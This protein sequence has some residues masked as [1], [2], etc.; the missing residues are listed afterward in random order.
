MQNLAHRLWWVQ[1]RKDSVADAGIFYKANNCLHFIYFDETGNEQS[2]GYSAL[3]VPLSG[4]R[5]TLAALKD[6]RKR[7]RASD[8][9]YTTREF[10]ATKFTSGRGR[11]GLPGRGISQQ[12]R[13]E[14]FSECLR[15]IANVPNVHL[16]NAFRSGDVKQIK[17]PLLEKLINRVHKS[18]ESW[19]SEGIL[20]F[21]EGDARNITK[22]ARKLSVFNPI[23]SKY[24]CWDDGREYRNFP[25]VRFPEDPIFR[26][27]GTSYLI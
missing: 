4:H 16:L 14:I 3:A 10:H 13:C 6:F 23:Q 19:G 25:L 20:F 5:E 21:D 12:R 7:I 18:V 2:I 1:P 17:M 24:G 9:I 8:G 26:G 22:L 11:L 15:A 27:S